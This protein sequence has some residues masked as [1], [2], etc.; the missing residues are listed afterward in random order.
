M[1]V[2][3]AGPQYRTSYT[4]AH[5][6]AEWDTECEGGSCAA[7]RRDVCTRYNHSN[8][9]ALTC[10]ALLRCAYV[11]QPEARR[12]V[13]EVLFEITYRLFFFFFL[14]RGWQDDDHIR[15][16]VSFECSSVEYGVHS[17]FSACFIFL[18][19]I[20]TRLFDAELCARFFLVFFRKSL[21]SF[22]PE[23]R[24]R[25]MC[26]IR[27]PVW[28]PRS[29]R[30]ASYVLLEDFKTDNMSKFLKHFHSLN[31]LEGETGRR[32]REWRT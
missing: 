5:P 16:A 15:L 14:Q 32:G 7:V 2:S 8:E 27:I 17:A 24:S 18:S 22:S 12:L 30:T 29:L 4:V 9:S 10:V 1:D 19:E 11:N 28:V 6:V 21:A 31:T 23:Q 13:S 25:K 20:L 26:S 3:R